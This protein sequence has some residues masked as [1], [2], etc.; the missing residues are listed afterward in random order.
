MNEKVKKISRIILSFLIIT[1]TG[2]CNWH[3]EIWNTLNTAESIIESHPDSALAILQNIPMSKIDEKKISA[4]YALLKSIALDKNLLDTTTFNILQPAIDYY[5]N[6][7]TPQ[8]KFRTYYYQGRIYQN[9]G[10][11]ES[12]MH[13]FMNACDL[14]AYVNDSLLVAHTHVALATLYYKQYKLNDFIHHNL[15]AAKHYGAIGKDIFQ[16]KSYTNAIDGYIMQNNKTAAD[17][18]LSVCVPLAQQN[19]TAEAYFFSSL[20][21]YTI[22]FGSAKDIKTFLNKYQGL[23]LTENKNID[24]ARGYSKIGEYNKAMTYLS[25]VQQTSTTLDSLKY[26]SVKSVILEKQEKYKEALQVYKQFSGI[27]EQ[28]QK[29]LLSQDLLFA[30]QKHQLEINNLLK[31]QERNKIIGT[32]ICFIFIL[33]IFSVWIYYRYHL[34]KTKHALAAKENEYLKLEHEDLLKEKE[35]TELEKNKKILEAEILKQIK[36]QLENELQEQEAQT[37]NLQQN[38]FKLETERNNLKKLLKEQALLSNPLQDIIKKRLDILNGLLAKEIS[39]NETYAKSYNNLLETVRNDKRKFMESMRH[40]FKASHPGF[41]E[42]LEQ[43]KLS[44]DE[45]NYLCLYAIGLRGKEVG[46]YIQLK[47]H[48]VMSHEIRMKLNMN[49]HETNIGLYIRRLLTQ[50]E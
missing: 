11:D 27:L 38:I 13:S 29:N 19:P 34:S 50:F 25:Q 24:F 32:T 4:R 44:D 48:Y 46:E 49:E 21:L 16:V 30:D 9:Q 17:S 35:L 1:A 22:E 18:L 26:T 39:Q 36:T 28:Y 47:R 20:L 3:N 43:H 41:I 37:A 31:I 2:S 6:Y 40:A 7:G 15:E 12:A 23:E 8:E 10:N 42:Y 33:V 5:S 45:I 14:E